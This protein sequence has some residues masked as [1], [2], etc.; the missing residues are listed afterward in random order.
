MVQIREEQIVY[1]LFCTRDWSDVLHWS[2]LVTEIQEYY[3]SKLFDEPNQK[4][5]KILKNGNKII[6][7][8][9]ALYGNSF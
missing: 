5:L 1:T 8:F 9:L 6:L 2:A 4:T 3:G 7:F